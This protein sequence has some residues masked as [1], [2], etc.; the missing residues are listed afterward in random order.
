MKRIRKECVRMEDKMKYE[1]PLGIREQDDK[2]CF[3]VAVERGKEC[4]LCIYKKGKKE[5][6]LEIE[7]SEE[8]AVG[9]VRFATL[10]KS[11][12][13]GKEYSYRIDGKEILDA[14]VQTVAGQSPL[15]GRVIFEE[16]DWEGDRGLQIPEDEIIAYN[17][18]VRGFTKSASSK[19][20]HKGTF[21]GVVEKIP[22]LKELGVNQ[23]QCMPVYCFEETETYKNYWGYGDAFS[24]AVKPS[25]GVKEPGKEL[26]DMVKECHKNGIEVILHLPFSGTVP[27]HRIVECLC[28]YVAEYHVDGFALNP[29]VAPMEEIFACPFLKKTKII[30]YR[31]DFQDIMRQFLKGDR[32]MVQGVIWWLKQRMT[33]SNSCNYMTNHAGFTLAD[34]VSY[35]GKHN[36][37]NGEENRD[38]TDQNYSWNCGEEGP[39][40]K[41]AILELRKRQMRNAICLLMTAQ[42]TPCL[43][44]GDEF[45]NSQDGNNNVYCQDNETAWLDWKKLEKEKEFWAFVK[46][47]IAIRKRYPVMRVKEDTPEHKQKKAPAISYHGSEAWKTPNEEYSRQLGVYY[48]DDEKG[49][50]F[51]AYNMHWNSMTFALPVLEDGKEWCRVISTFDGKRAEEL[52]VEKNQREVKIEGRTIV[53]FEGK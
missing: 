39:T 25:Y 40:R 5:P 11:K 4:I 17:L 51:I 35:N 21:A 53:I 2:V 6:E 9:E 28:F 13:K 1:L 10:P 27:Y 38:G 46:E 33:D 41:K 47:M 48:H 16:Y 37:D 50:C 31:D 45:A 23:I 8:H 7:L 34:L 52:I 3:S 14:Y 12:V 32:N 29:F 24:F 22:Y 49:D 42:G 20:K 30:R 15:R 19:V 44:A 43:L 18:H 26:K 36:E